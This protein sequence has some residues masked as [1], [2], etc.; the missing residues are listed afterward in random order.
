MINMIES[1]VN[2][3]VTMLGV[4]IIGCGT[5]TRLRHAPEY[6]RNADCRLIAL[7]DAVPGRAA[8]LAALY[9]AQACG[10]YHEL[11]A[12]PDI[13]A[14]SVCTA[15][16]THAAIAREAMLAGKHVLCEKPM[17]LTDE[18]AAMLCAVSRRTG[19][20]L[21][22]AFN[23]RLFPACRNA[24]AILRS[25]RLGRV[26]S[27]TSAFRHAGPETWS[28][29]SGRGCWFFKREAG[30]G[31]LSDLAVHKLD[32]MNALLGEPITEIA[33]DLSTLDKRDESGAPIE[34]CDNATL[35]CRTK[36]GV[37]GVIIASWSDYGAEENGTA[38][39]CEK[40]RLL[41]NPF[42]DVDLVVETRGGG[43]EVQRLG[44]APTNDAQKPSGVID[45][46]VDAALGRAEPMATAEDGLNNVRAMNAAL[47]SPIVC[48]R[49]V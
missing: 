12:R 6:A 18:D 41:I 2:G 13:G 9:G 14:V 43:R 8:Q 10:D 31:V 28:V 49:I 23:Q 21:V 33:A 19:R 22:P 5:I 24:R 45:A 16:Q 32:L 46:F 34:V 36:S 1:D 4:G 25:G 47:V 26:I 48:R 42:P 20:L 27:F 15:N 35:F 7:A 37:Q 3:G 30:C 11:L 39:Y 40:G 29:D 44:G 17:A 38:L